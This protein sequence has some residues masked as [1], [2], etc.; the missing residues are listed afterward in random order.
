M[1][2]TD[3]LIEAWLESCPLPVVARVIHDKEDLIG[4][5][6]SS[7][8]YEKGHISSSAIKRFIYTKER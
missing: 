3:K 6:I 2:N 4:L 8:L 7:P 1:N 5:S